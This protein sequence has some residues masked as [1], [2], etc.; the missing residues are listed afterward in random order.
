M[1]VREALVKCDASILDCKHPRRYAVVTQMAEPSAGNRANSVWRWE[2]AQRPWNDLKEVDG[3]LVSESVESAFFE[4]EAQKR[5][6]ELQQFRRG[7]IRALVV[8]IDMSRNGIESRDFG[9][10]R[11][12]LVCEHLTKF[13]KAYLDQNPLSEIS[14]VTTRGYC[15]YVESP[16]SSDLDTHLAAVRKLRDIST[17]GQPSLSNS[18]QVAS[19]VL[20]NAPDFSTREVLFVYGSMTSCDPEPLEA[21]CAKLS[22]SK[23]G[24]VVS[25]IG[26]CAKVHVLEKIVEVTGGLYRVPTSAEQLEDLFQMH[27]VPPLW[28]KRTQFWRMVPFGFVKPV[29]EQL[30]FDIDEMKGSEKEAKPKRANLACPKCAT[31]LFKVPSYCPICRTLVMT[32]AHLTRSLQHLKPLASF[33]IYEGTGEYCAGCNVMLPERHLIC[34]ACQRHF[35]HEC[36][37][38]VHE[39][40]QNCPGCLAK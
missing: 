19:A 25:A 29:P 31:K 16:L 37:K 7:L 5:R 36:D 34:G 4:A 40:L 21:L 32:P 18:L 6:Q 23:T 15:G 10:L 24:M 22:E 12:K 2:Q 28:S 13:L 39:C 30:A 8:V 17:W 14:I 27:V 20:A 26:F 11:F 1:E 33:D 9:V 35:C 38:F 3:R